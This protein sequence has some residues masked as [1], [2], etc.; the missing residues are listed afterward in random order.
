MTDW[1][2]PP[3]GDTREQLPDHLL[4]LIDMPS[5]LSTACEAAGAL[6][7][8]AGTRREQAG[9]LAA[10]QERLHARCRTNNK[11]TGQLCMCGCHKA[12]RP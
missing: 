6:E 9:E 3:P 4:A 12:G 8:A 2:P 11:Y 7:T 10:W 1:M 5:Y